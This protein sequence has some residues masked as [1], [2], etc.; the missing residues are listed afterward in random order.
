MEQVEADRLLDLYGAALR[1][2]FSDIPDDDLRCDL[3]GDE[4]RRIERLY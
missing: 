2:F 1:A 4:S 3:F